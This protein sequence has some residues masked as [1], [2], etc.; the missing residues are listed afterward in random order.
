MIFNT[1]PVPGSDNFTVR[2]ISMAQG[3]E[4][5]VVFVVDGVEVPDPLFIN[6]DQAAAVA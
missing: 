5:P 3:A 4:A 6:E 2:G 1:T